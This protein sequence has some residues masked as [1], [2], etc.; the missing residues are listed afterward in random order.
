MNL[1]TTALV[2]AT[3]AAA[4]VFVAGALWAVGSLSSKSDRNAARIAADARARTASRADTCAAF[5][6]LFRAQR[7]EIARNDVKFQSGAYDKT[8][9]AFATLEVKRLT[10]RNAVD[11]F[12]RFDNSK[13]PSY[14]P[15]SK[16]PTPLPKGF[17]RP[18][19]I[20]RARTP[21]RERR[22]SSTSSR[23]PGGRHQASTNPPRAKRRS[24]IPRN[25]P[26]KYSPPATPPPTSSSPPAGPSGPPGQERPRG[27]LAPI[28]DRLEHLPLC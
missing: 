9:P 22:R 11:S 7:N 26:P 6:A 4:A 2:V 8:L 13:L 14:C 27:I 20:G 10:H 16:R 15:Q 5:S 18:R 24:S 3:T 28:C 23:T 12:N 17:R 19:S 1:R 25:I 21:A